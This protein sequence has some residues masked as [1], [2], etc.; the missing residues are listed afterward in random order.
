MELREK[1]LACEI[2]RDLLPLYIDEM[3]SDVSKKSIDN[4]LEQCTE[5]SEIYQDMTCHLQMETP[6]T[7]ISD[8]KRFL[9]KTKKMYFLYGLG[10]LS[11]IAVLVCLIVDLAVNK[12]I[13]WS[14]IVG[15]SCLFADALLYALFTCKKDKICTSMA[16]I[17]VGAFVLLSV[18]QITRYYLLGTGTVWLFRYGLPIL[19]L[20]LLVLWLPVL[21]GTFLKWNI[22]DCTALFL[23]LVIIGNYATKL[24]TG[25]YVWEDVFHMQGFTGNAL[26]EVIGIMIFVMVGRV[27]KWKK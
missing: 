6:P 2:V 4:H 13:T 11:F 20:W 27:T 7:E 1:E 14:L 21:G 25:D 18:I 16:V 15:S 3:V 12:G 8:V 17:S 5:C 10:G 23:F 24:I 26:G 9:K 22:W 19:L